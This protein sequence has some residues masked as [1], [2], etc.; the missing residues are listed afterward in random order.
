[1][2]FRKKDHPGQLIHLE[3]E[4]SIES[5]L[6]RIESKLDLLLQG[7]DVKVEHVIE[8]LNGMSVDSKSDF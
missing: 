1:M 8:S 5:K 4:D 3:H 6:D 7:Q 2:F